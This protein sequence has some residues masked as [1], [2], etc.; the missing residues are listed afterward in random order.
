MEFLAGPKLCDKNNLQ[1]SL[2]EL[3]KESNKLYQRT[4]TS[5]STLYSLM[6]CLVDFLLS[7]QGPQVNLVL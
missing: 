1:K 3:Y 6:L 2:Q 7:C 5:W 4:A